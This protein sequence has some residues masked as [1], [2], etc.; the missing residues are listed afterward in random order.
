MSTA[1]GGV[2]DVLLRSWR[3]KANLLSLTQE[4]DAFLNSKGVLN[5]MYFVLYSKC[6]SVPQS[7]LY[8]LRNVQWLSTLM[9][10]S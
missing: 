8:L 6:H 2:G 7:A 9:S 3:D 1:I 4:L 10:S 5:N